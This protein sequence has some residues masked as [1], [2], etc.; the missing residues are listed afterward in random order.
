M[1]RNRKYNNAA[2]RL[3]AFRL[4]VKLGTAPGLAQPSSGKRT[5]KTISRPARLLALQNGAQAL[6]DEYQ[7]WRDNLPESLQESGLA[8]KLDEAIDKFTDVT[9]TLADIDLPKGFGRD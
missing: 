2:D 8:S 9:D 3:K 4:R 5:A 6:L 7:A 1:G